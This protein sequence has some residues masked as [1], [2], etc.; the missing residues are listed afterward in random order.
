MIKFISSLQHNDGQLPSAMRF[1]HCSAADKEE[2][3]EEE[4]AAFS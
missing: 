2:E 3:E 4:E 1:A